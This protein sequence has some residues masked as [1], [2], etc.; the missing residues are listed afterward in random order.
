M[1]DKQLQDAIDQIEHVKGVVKDID[2]NSQQLAQALVDG[3]KIVITT[4]Q[5][6]PFIMRGLLNIAGADSA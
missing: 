4:I 2:Q 5:K 1:L 3:T 6:F